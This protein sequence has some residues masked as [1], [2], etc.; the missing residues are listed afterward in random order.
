[1][2]RR[3]WHTPSIPALGRQR[4][5][6]L[7]EFKARLVYKVSSR[8][9]SKTIQRNLVSKNKKQNKTK[10]SSGDADTNNRDSSPLP[11]SLQ[12]DNSKEINTRKCHIAMTYEFHLRSCIDCRFKLMLKENN[13]VPGTRLAWILLILMLEDSFT[14]FGVHH[15]RN[16]AF[17]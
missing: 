3:W 12:E 15:N 14:G 13:W 11:E 9:A 2:A 8:T 7:C 1:M 4:Q 16:K 5:A 6:D 17:K 10:Q